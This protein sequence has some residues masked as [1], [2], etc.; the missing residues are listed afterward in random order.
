M[1]KVS[2]KPVY[3]SP[4]YKIYPYP[5]GGNVSIIEKKYV[6]FNPRTMASE[7]DEKDIDNFLDGIL[8]NKEIKH[9]NDGY[10]GRTVAQEYTVE[11][12]DGKKMIFNEHKYYFKSVP[13]TN[14]T[15]GRRKTK[16]NKSKKRKTR[17]RKH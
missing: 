6:K 17:S 3:M 16:K 1:I 11:L 10:D 4:R 2:E 9:S 14:I 13:P 12:N 5:I 7:V 8:V 15:G